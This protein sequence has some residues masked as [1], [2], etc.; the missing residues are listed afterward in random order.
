MPRHEEEYFPSEVGSETEVDASDISKEQIHQTFVTG[1]DWTTETILGQLRQGNI[2]LNPAFQRREVWTLNKKSALIESIILGMPI[3][4]IVL[5]ATR[6]DPNAYIV[7]D[8]K[9]RLVTIRQ[10]C[11]SSD[12]DSDQAFTKLSLSGLKIRDDLNNISYDDLIS[13]PT[14]ASVLR[15]F[16]NH[17]IRTVVIRNWSTEDLLHK[18]FWRLNSGSV[19]LSSQELRQA[20]Y[21][22]RFMSFLDDFAIDSR[23]IQLA[24]GIDQADFRMRD[25]EVLLRHLAFAFDANEYPGNL[26]RFLDNFSDR[27]NKSWDESET[28]IQDEAEQ[29]EEAI[30]ATLTIFGQYDSFSTYNGTTF[31]GRFNRAVFDIMTYYF[32]DKALRN[33]ALQNPQDVKQSFERIS[34]TDPDFQRSLTI[35]TKSKSATA[36]RFTVWAAELS[37]VTGLE[38]SPPTRFSDELR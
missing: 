6:E 1:S 22:G 5:A 10:F 16:N 28:R 14:K 30:K 3:P 19:P 33:A 21:P 2:D 38:V 17:T 8:G 7:L 9:Q 36:T 26:K 32:S 13:D 20:L 11:A 24:L 15:A 37:A 31:E 25:N 34:S 27:M 18:I 35:T 23:P 29:C 12:D 4:Q